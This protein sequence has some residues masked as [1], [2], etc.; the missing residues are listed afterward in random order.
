MIRVVREVLELWEGECVV[1]PA[2]SDGASVTPVA[3]RIETAAGPDILNRLEAMGE[4]PLGSAVLTPGGD[5]P[6]RFL[7]HVVLQ[8]EQEPVTVETVR[9]ATANA[10]ARAA[11]FGIEALAFPPLGTH[12]GQ[13][14]SDDA[15]RA[16]AAAVTEHR[17][18]H[19]QPTDVVVVVES[20][21]DRDVFGRIVGGEQA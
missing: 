20:E 21:Y 16:M 10:L 5:L 2:R 1:R 11:D 7:L 14:E 3:R 4:L 15:A 9:R 18:R 6:V 17:M 13:L 12:A 8:S 19:E